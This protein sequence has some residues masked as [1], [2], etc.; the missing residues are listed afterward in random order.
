MKTLDNPW[1]IFHDWY[2]QYREVPNINDHSVMYL[3]TVEENGSTFVPNLR[4]VLLKKYNT[5]G[6]TFFTNMESKKGQDI[7]N[8]PNVTLLFYWRECKY[9]ITINGTA[10]T[11][12]E[13]ESDI[14]YKSRPFM[15]NVSSWASKQS[16][17]MDQ[18]L[19][20]INNIEYYRKKYL[21]SPIPRPEYW[22]GIIVKPY[23]FE[24]WHEKE[25][26][27]HDRY[28]FKLVNQ[29]WQKNKLYP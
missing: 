8:N 6:F 28:E 7:Q 10:N 17:I 13:E 15:S 21:N 3:A 23:R 27:C 22:K 26:R 24:F 19:D 11:I 18:E 25:Y 29:I 9:Q 5:S 1:D 12:S 14:Y 4:T 2:T 16:K 20:F